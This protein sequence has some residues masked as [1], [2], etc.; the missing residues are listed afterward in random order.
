VPDRAIVARYCVLAGGLRFL[1]E[2]IRVNHLAALGLTV[3]Q[4]GSLLLVAAGITLA[5]SGSRTGA[6]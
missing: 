5:W 4:W 2:F 6:S 3:A 1:L